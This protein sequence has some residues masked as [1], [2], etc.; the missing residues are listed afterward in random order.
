MSSMK[1]VSHSSPTI[2]FTL[3]LWNEPLGNGQSEWRGEIKNLSTGEVR[4]FRMGE[5]ITVLVFGMLC[6]RSES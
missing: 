3:R 6:G 5:E 2:I 4:Y 1:G